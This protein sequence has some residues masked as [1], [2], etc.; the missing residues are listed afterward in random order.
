MQKRQQIEGQ[1]KKD[2]ID[3]EN[4]VN[5]QAKVGLEILKEKKKKEK[6]NEKM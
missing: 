1:L 6:Q 4:K 2:R 3:H 5:E